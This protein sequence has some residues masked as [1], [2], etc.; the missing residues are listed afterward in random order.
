MFVTWPKNISRGAVCTASVAVYVRK[1]K[2]KQVSGCACVVA[3]PGSMLGHVCELCQ[4]VHRA[5]EICFSTFKWSGRKGSLLGELNGLLSFIFPG[6]SL[7]WTPAALSDLKIMKVTS[8]CVLVG[9][10]VMESDRHIWIGSKK[11]TYSVTDW[12]MELQT[13]SSTWNGHKVTDYSK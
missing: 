7:C 13:Q 9:K 5:S 11:E 6:I 10:C 4:P 1:L 2:Q 8:V 12:L 3:F